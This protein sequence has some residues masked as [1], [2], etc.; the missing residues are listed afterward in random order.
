MG[1][2]QLLRDPAD[3]SSGVERRWLAIPVDALGEAPPPPCRNQLRRPP[4]STWA[5][6]PAAASAVFGKVSDLLPTP[7]GA[8]PRCGRFSPKRRPCGRTPQWSAP[9]ASPVQP[10]RQGGEGRNRRP[11]FRPSPRRFRS[12]G[13][14]PVEEAGW[15]SPRCGNGPHFEHRVS[16]CLNLDLFSKFRPSKELSRVVAAS[17][18]YVIRSQAP[19]NRDRTK[20]R[21]RQVGPDIV[22]A[23]RQQKNGCGPSIA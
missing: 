10:C 3:R 17:A 7:G 19:R 21:A 23:R 1:A 6:P 16:K 13:A 18:S 14:G 12:L 11:R 8:V 4:G 2:D 15:I 9:A 22:L 20:R 5:R